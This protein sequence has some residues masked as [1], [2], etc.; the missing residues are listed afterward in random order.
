MNAAK[1]AFQ[2]GS[3][4]RSMD[5]SARGQLIHKL[6]ELIDTHKIHLANLESLDNG[7]PF[8]DSLLDVEMTVN[9]FKYY[10]GFADKIHGKTILAGIHIAKYYLN[11]MQ[12][13]FMY[14]FMFSRWTTFFI[15]KTS[16]YRRCW[17]N[18][19]LELPN[20][21]VSM[22]VGTSSCIWMYSCIKTR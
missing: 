12:H 14:I 18:N 5:A 22:E 9:T 19:T 16:T 15:Y 21:N 1:T 6:S 20:F 13:Q 3:Q 10:A 7:K 4:W 11:I 17:T 8:A 2:P